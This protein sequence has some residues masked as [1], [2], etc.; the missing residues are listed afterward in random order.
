MGDVDRWVGLNIKMIRGETPQAYV[1]DKMTARGYKWS[2]STVWS[3][4]AGRRPLKVSE[5]VDLSVILDVPLQMIVVGSG[6]ATVIARNRARAVVRANEVLE[7]AVSGYEH[8][9][10]DLG[11]SIRG[12]LQWH[13]ELDEEWV[14]MFKQTA[15]EVAKDFF[16]NFERRFGPAKGLDDGV[17]P[18]E[19]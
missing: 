16:E 19:G 12:V 6:E 7:E 5:A 13:E 10:R 2:Q 11:E 8:A 18:E 1:A 3:V 9:R 15:P 14:K 17:D 4:E